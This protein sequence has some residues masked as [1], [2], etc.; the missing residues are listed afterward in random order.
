VT[1]SEHSSSA[2]HEAAAN[3]GAVALTPQELLW[4][5]PFFSALT[6][7]DVLQLRVHRRRMSAGEI[8]F[9]KGDPGDGLYG[10]L[11]GRVAFTVDSADGRQLILN[12][13]GPGE[14]FGEI[15]L[16]DGK[17]RSA[18]GVAR[19]DGELLF[20]ARG[21]FLAFFAERP[22]EMLQIV[23]LLCDRLRR[24]TDYIADSAF[25]GLS[26]RLARQLVMLLNGRG[27]ALP[28]GLRISHAELAS[29]L[30]V[31]RE[32]VS[33]QL[34]AW[35]DRGILDQGRGRLIVRDRRALEHVI[36]GSG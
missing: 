9:H 34:A 4:L 18:T 13:L 1:D 25:L 5:H 17:G 23:V 24:S 32:R 27:P 29:M 33:R 31:S 20:I 10:V 28:A 21:D 26:R 14:F 3:I 12:I 7:R 11:A 2:P 35:S 8:L 36:T 6:P 30:G 16:L 15:A 19:D 22:D